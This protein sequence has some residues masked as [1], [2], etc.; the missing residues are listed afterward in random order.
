MYTTVAEVLTALDMKIQERPLLKHL[1]SQA[2]SADAFSSSALQEYS[3]Q[4]DRQGEVFPTSVSAI[5]ANCPRPSVHQQ[6]LENLLEEERGAD[7]HSEL[8]LR[9]AEALG[10]PRNAVTNTAPLPETSSLIQT[11]RTLTC[12]HSHPAGVAT[13]LAYEAQVLEVAETKIAGLK[14][15]CGVD[16]ARGLAFFQVQLRVDRFHAETARQILRE[17]VTSENVDE[18]VSSCAQAIDAL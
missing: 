5:H 3:K 9:F 6:L 15:F 1:F 18:V 14:Q 13:L 12:G 11:F 10:A 17:Y 8:C 16:N 2:W 4:S 7:N